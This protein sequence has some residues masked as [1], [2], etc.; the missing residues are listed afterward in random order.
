MYLISY[1]SFKEFNKE[2]INLKLDTLQK[3]IQDNLDILLHKD[4]IILISYNAITLNLIGFIIF[5]SCDDERFINILYPWICNIYIKEK[6]RKLGICKLMLFKLN[7]IIKVKK[8][9]TY[10][11]Y[12]KKELIKYYHKLK[13]KYIYTFN[14][15]NYIKY[16]FQYIP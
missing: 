5:D 15:G 16:I 10:Y 6:Y 4:G 9:N 1:Y 11:L 14:Q 12:C 3:V 8:Y 7:K 2:Y 13:Y